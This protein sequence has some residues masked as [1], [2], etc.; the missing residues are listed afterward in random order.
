M[1]SHE[2]V[3]A[4]KGRRPKGKDGEA[5]WLRS[6]GF[7]G[8]YHPDPDMDCGCFNDDLRPCGELDTPCRGG[9]AKDGG[10]FHP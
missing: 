2:Q 9:K 8:L 1:T 10:V 7:D 4:P 5:D 6:R 3:M